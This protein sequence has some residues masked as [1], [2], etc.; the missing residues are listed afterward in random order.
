MQGSRG[1]YPYNLGKH[2]IAAIELWAYGDETGT[3]EDAKFC[4]L[5]GYV[6]SP[7]Q[8]SSFKRLWRRILVEHEVT[9]FHSIDFFS[10]AA[11]RERVSSPYH[12][13][14]A[15]KRKAFLDRLLEVISTHRIMPI[16]WAV[17]IEDFYA[18]RED[19]RRFFTGAYLDYRLNARRKNLDI[20]EPLLTQITR[21]FKSSGA[22]SRPYFVAFN[23]FLDDAVTAAKAHTTIHIVCDAQNVFEAWAIESFH[24]SWKQRKGWD[25]D[26]NTFDGKTLE[27]LTYTDSASEPALQAADLY[28]YVW[29][30]Y[31]NGSTTPLI[32]DTIKRLT[33]RK[34]YLFVADADYFRQKLSQ[35]R[36]HGQHKFGDII[37]GVTDGAIELT[38]KERP[39][40]D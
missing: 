29:G 22:P 30:R 31:L 19:E 32:K 14:D 4:L 9:E 13:W 2:L 24:Q 20:N 12:N 39:P 3:Q 33:S 25:R 8:W 15:A 37:A 36:A 28:A 17:R 1:R 7:H 23:R 21:K 6:G 34:S 10:G 35:L 40:H 38:F 26:R 18:L 11:R 27:S 5:V 16:G